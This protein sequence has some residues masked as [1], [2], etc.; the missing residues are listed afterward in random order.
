MKSLD[1]SKIEA[2]KI[3]LAVTPVDLSELVRET[4][5][6]QEGQVR[7]KPVKLVAEIPPKVAT[8][9]TDPQRLKQVI[10]NLIGNALKFTERGS[11]TV[12][13]VTEPGTDAPRR[14]DVTDTGIGIPQDR[15]GV[16]FEAFQQADA[17][18][19]RRYGGTGLGLTISQALC[20]LMGYRIEVSSQVGAGS[21]FSVLLN[22]GAVAAHNL[23]APTT[24][25][26]AP[27]RAPETARENVAPATVDLKSKVVLIIDDEEDSRVLL[28][29]T[30]EEA[31]FRV[32]GAGSG[33]EGL[34]LARSLHPDLIS[35]DLLMPGLS[36]WEL[37]RR[38]KADP[39][40]RSIPVIV[41]SVIA[42]ENTGRMFGVVDVLQKPISREDLLAV[43]HC[44]LSAPRP[45][46]LVVDDDPDIRQILTSYLLDSGAQVRT[47]ANGGEALE[48]LE[49]GLPDLILLDLIMP[50]MDGMTFLDALRLH[51][52]WQN[53]AVAVITSKDLTAEETQRL[54]QETLEVVPKAAVFNGELKQLLQR[55]LQRAA[56][57]RTSG[58]AEAK[59]RR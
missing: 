16:I 32:I 46:I 49:E 40:L 19:S 59:T 50:V 47:A 8:L 12:R 27:A 45:T 17:S 21:T 38:I 3:E 22:P 53:I 48:Q 15:L 29:H 33:E 23:A 20:Q 31:G 18:T 52:R 36:G 30:V 5:T 35:V 1:L 11:V 56:L 44:N 26:P 34:S 24:A 2:H 28:K 42:S 10:I 39:E 54:K 41:V 7:D 4:V 43:L 9:Q 58:Q 51:P 55:L 6:Q 25:L 57:A 13:V 37:V 14:I